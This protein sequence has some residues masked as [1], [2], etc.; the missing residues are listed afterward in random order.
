MTSNPQW[1]STARPLLLVLRA[2]VLLVGCA[3]PRRSIRDQPKDIRWLTV[4]LQHRGI[5]IRETGSAFAEMPSKSDARLIV[6]SKETLDTY[7]FESAELARNQAYK[8]SGLYPRND[9]FVVEALVV[10]RFNSSG[11]GLTHALVEVLGTPI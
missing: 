8:L 1:R 7:L 3:G 5:M 2:S 9:I 11:S 6:D 4:Q 10:V